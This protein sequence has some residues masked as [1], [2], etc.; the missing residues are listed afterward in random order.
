VLIVLEEKNGAGETENF[1]LSLRHRRIMPWQRQ[2]VNVFCDLSINSFVCPVVFA[3]RL[4]LAS[5]DL[6]KKSARATSIDYLWQSVAFEYL[7]D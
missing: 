3:E 6:Q 7:L 2:E 5:A 1:Q 4:E